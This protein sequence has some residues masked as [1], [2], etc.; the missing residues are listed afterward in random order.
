MS[1]VE[2]GFVFTYFTLIHEASCIANIQREGWVF[3]YMCL[4]A[5][6]KKLIGIILNVKNYCASQI[7]FF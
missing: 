5:I 3:P 6:L 7:L 2:H 4:K 1:R